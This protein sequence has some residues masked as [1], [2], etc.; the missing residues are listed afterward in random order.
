MTTG[1][2]RPQFDVLIVGAGISGIGAGIELLRRGNPAFLILE[3]ATDLGGT[4][5]DN[6]YPG[7]A[8]DIASASYCFSFETDYLWSNTFARGAEIQA[9]VRHCAEKY[10]VARHIK[11]GARALR[12]RFDDDTWITELHDGSV[13]TSRYLIAATGLFG[14]PRL[15]NIP[16]LDRFAG[17]AMHSAQWDQAYDLSAKRVAVIGTGASAV[18]LVPEIAPRVAHLSVFQRTPIWVAPRREAPLDRG[19]PRSLRRFASVRRALRAFSEFEIAVL[20]FLIVNYRPMR[21]VV[22]LVE[23][24]VRAWMRREVRDPDTMARLL[25]SYGLGCKRPATSNRYLATFN[26]DNVS[27]VTRPIARVTAEGIITDDGVLHEADAIVLATGFPTTDKG[28]GPTFEVVGRDGVELGHWWEAHRR[29]AYAGVSAPRFPNFFLTAG[30]YSGGFNWFAMLEAN[31][32]H[33]MACIDG[34]RARGVTRVEVRSDA[35]ERYMRHIWRRADGAV[36]THGVCAGSNSYYIDRHGDASLPLPHTPWW[37]VLTARRT[38]DYRF[39]DGE[40]AHAPATAMQG[41]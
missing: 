14:P 15:P 41:T 20:T 27:L 38:G 34:A 31:L 24:G 19:S 25:P 8:V 23:R 1:R 39:G 40:H 11:Y 9:Y 35:H 3:A 7:V 28:T 22:R 21:P 13:L 16:G 18:Q 37:R 36:F 12:S 2:S 5:R 29:Q 10:G 30:P 17:R 32:A 33:I 4:W 26:R 6:T